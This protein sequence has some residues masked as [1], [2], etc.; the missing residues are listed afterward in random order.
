MSLSFC[1]FFYVL[2]L[3]YVQLKLYPLSY[4]SFILL[5]YYSIIIYMLYYM[6]CDGL[7]VS[8]KG[9]LSRGQWIESSLNQFLL[10]TTGVNSGLGKGIWSEKFRHC[11]K[12]PSMGIGTRPEKI[13][14]CWEISLSGRKKVFRCMDH[15]VLRHPSYRRGFTYPFS[16]SVTLLNVFM[17]LDKHACF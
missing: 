7:G 2:V 12:I 5:F 3:L 1:P 10:K 8:A 13:P 14:V 4:Y 17:C 9:S 6:C 11:G 15:L 16:F